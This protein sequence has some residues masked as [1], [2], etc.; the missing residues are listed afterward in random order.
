VLAAWLAGVAGRPAAQLDVITLRQQIDRSELIVRG[1]VEPPDVLVPVD[2]GPT[3]QAFVR[4]TRTLKGATAGGRVDVG[5]LY[6][7]R[8]DPGVREERVRAVS[9]AT[10]WKEGED[11]LAFLVFDP[12]LGRYHAQGWH[13][14]VRS[15]TAEELDLLAQRVAER[16]EH[17]R[18]EDLEAAQREWTVELVEHPLTRADG[19]ADLR[20][21]PDEL[22][23]L[24]D[25]QLARLVRVAAA[26][27]GIDQASAG[28]YELV[29]DV[30]DPALTRSLHA[31]LRRQVGECSR[32]DSYHSA[33]LLVL[34]GR[35]VG[36]SACTALAEECARIVAIT[37]EEFP[38]QGT[39]HG[40]MA[41]RDAWQEQLRRALDCMEH[42]LGAPTAPSAPSAPAVP[43]ELPAPR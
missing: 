37:P 5:G 4:I 33:R 14:G 25:E 19:V 10:A 28:L 31:A 23:P 29:A 8:P 39:M 34:L 38:A 24:S 11:V 41:W 27:N 2:E 32:S 16:M 13:N 36:D 17:G 7:P 20:A 30:P 40:G 18:A 22:R 12:S 6:C 9:H 21:H 35:R 3:R 43:S 26:S 15:G 1:T 42:H